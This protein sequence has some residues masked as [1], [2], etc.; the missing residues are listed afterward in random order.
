MKTLFHALLLSL[1]YHVTQVQDTRVET[2]KVAILRVK[3]ICTAVNSSFD[4]IG[5]IVKHG[6]LSRGRKS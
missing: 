4:N 2:H 5:G 3:Y 1:G 6:Y